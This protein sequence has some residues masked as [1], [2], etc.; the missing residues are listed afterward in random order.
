[1]SDHAISDLRST[2]SDLRSTG[3]TDGEPSDPAAEEQAQRTF[4]LSILVSAIRCTLTYVIFPF[5]A[6]LVGLASGV[7]AGVGVVIG[8]VAIV[9]NVFS[10]RRFWAAD[11]KWK[12]PMTAL[13][14]GIIILLSILLVVDLNTLL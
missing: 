8:V 1:M 3:R 13:N 10:I 7:G 5:V 4:S 6:P 2:G 9:A 11:H 14:G 12:M